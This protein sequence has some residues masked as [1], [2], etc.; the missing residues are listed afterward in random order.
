MVAFCSTRH[1]RYD[2]NLLSCLKRER[3][4][5][6]NLQ[7]GVDGQHQQGN[8]AQVRD[9]EASAALAHTL[10]ALE[11][12]CE[13]PQHAKIESNPYRFWMYAVPNARHPNPRYPTTRPIHGHF[14]PRPP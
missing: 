11:A 8:V 6:G 12:T 4:K 7:A 3:H 1:G 2:H 14:Q 13:Y 5:V 10:L 9:H